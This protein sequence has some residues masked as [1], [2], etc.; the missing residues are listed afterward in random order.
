MRASSS[1]YELAILVVGKEG[2][3][4]GNGKSFSLEVGLP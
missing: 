3:L 4:V 2:K 1:A